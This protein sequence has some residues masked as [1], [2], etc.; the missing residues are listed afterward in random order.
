MKIKQV[1]PEALKPY[2]KNP[3]NITR[4]AIDE[5]KK[6]ITNTAGKLQQ[7][8]VVDSK[9]VII[10]GHT[11]QLAAIELGMKTV[12]VHVADY[13]S[14]EQ[15]RVYRI[16]DNKTGEFSEWSYDPLKLEHEELKELDVDFSLTSLKMV[17]LCH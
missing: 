2:P 17:I 4:K 10:V 14:D 5:C 16:A 15:A 7:P 6:S 1:T 8:I 13:L 3:R 12:P 11:R 9:M